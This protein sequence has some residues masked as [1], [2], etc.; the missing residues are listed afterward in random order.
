MLVVYRIIGADG[1]IYT[2]VPGFLNLNRNYRSF[3]IV[4]KTENRIILAAEFGSCID[5]LMNTDGGND[6]F[7]ITCMQ[8][9]SVSVL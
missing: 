1:Q 2:R 8:K 7:P 5:V 4:P 3:T 9:I 6:D